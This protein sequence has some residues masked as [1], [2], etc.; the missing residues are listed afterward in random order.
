MS[1]E[2]REI[3]EST[4]IHLHAYGSPRPTD[5]QYGIFVTTD[6]TVDSEQKNLTERATDSREQLQYPWASKISRVPD[7]RAHV[8]Y[9]AL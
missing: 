8:S 1:R 4:S 3:D 7:S 6:I 9:P 2:Y 5:R